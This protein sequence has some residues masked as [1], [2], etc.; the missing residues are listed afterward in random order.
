MLSQ[1]IDYHIG[2]LLREQYSFLLPDRKCWGIVTAVS[3]RTINIMWFLDEEQE[4]IEYFRDR[5]DRVIPKNTS[6]S[7]HPYP[8]D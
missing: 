2:D 3:Q 1:P 6:Y 4:T 7:Y 5:L 8:R